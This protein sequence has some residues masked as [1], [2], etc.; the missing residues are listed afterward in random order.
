MSP[1]ERRNALDVVAVFMRDE[2][3]R[4]VFRNE[5]QAGEPIARLLQREAA[6]DQ[7]A[8]SVDR[9]Q[10]AVAATAAAER[11]EGRGTSRGCEKKR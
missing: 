10:G 5:A 6:V 11:R 1:R 9:N 4:Q 7:Q 8:D 3:R 2:D